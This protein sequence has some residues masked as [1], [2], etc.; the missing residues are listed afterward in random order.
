MDVRVDHKKGWRPK[1]I[2]LN[3]GVGETLESPLDCKEIQ[4]VRSK[5]NQPW[6]FIGR[7]DAEA[8]TPILWPSDAKSWLIGKYPDDGKDWRQE[9]KGMTEEEMVGWHHCLDGHGFEQTPGVGD[10][11]GSL[12]CCSPRGCKDSDMT[13]QLNNNSSFIVTSV[14]FSSVSQSCLTLCDPMDARL[15]C[16]PLSPGVCSN[17]CPL[18]QWCYIIILSSAAPFSFSLQSFPG[19]GSFPMSKLFASGGQS[20]GASASVSGLPMNT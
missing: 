3:C 16:P 1:L 8:E 14:Q 18:S 6:I 17:S 20:I 13:E 12:E 11:Q 2:L 9:K 10:G 4:P 15:P 7:T 19:S 5:G